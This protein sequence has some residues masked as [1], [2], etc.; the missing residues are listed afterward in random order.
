VR[1]HYVSII[2]EKEPALGLEHPKNKFPCRILRIVE[3]VFST[4]VNVCPL[5]ADP[6]IDFSRIR[7][8]LP[9]GAIGA[10]RE[11]DVVEAAIKPDDIM[12]LLRDNQDTTQ[13]K[14]WYDTAG[15]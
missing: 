15:S 12:P 3:D 9:K 11:G 5:D 1:A 8:E 10:A 14:M 6:Q 13:R 4:I 7:A 2:S